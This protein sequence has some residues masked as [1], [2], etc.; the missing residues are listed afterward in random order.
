LLFPSAIEP[1]TT[2]R[3]KERNTKRKK[4]ERDTEG[5]SQEERES[6]REG[7][8]QSNKRSEGGG[9]GRVSP[10]HSLDASHLSLETERREQ[11]LIASALCVNP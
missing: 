4:E 7:E 11:Q 6:E 9:T 3:D 5:K 1:L 2:R 8:S 10:R